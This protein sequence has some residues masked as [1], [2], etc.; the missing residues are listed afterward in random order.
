MSA[1]LQEVAEHVYKS[2]PQL[3]QVTVVF[4]NRRAALYFRKYLAEQLQRPVFTPRLL[5]I[6][7]FFQQFSDLKVPDKLELIYDLYSV[8][9]RIVNRSE[10][11]QDG[12]EGLE[13]FYFWGEMLLRDFDEADKYMVEAGHL[14]K[15]LSHQKEL[16]SSFDYLTDEQRA[17]LNDFWG[18][19]DEH[20]SHHKKKFISF[21][22]KLPEIY[23]GF[24][25]LLLETGR[26]FEGML[27]RSV[28]EQLLKG[29]LDLSTGPN[30]IFAGF[31]ALTKAE[32]HVLSTFVS[33]GAR[34]FW[35][36]DAYYV[37]NVTQE[38]GRFFREYLDHPVLRRTFP[39]NIPSHRLFRKNETG[40]ARLKVYGA[41]QPVGQAKLMSQIIEEELQK[42]MDPTETVIV[43]PDEKLLLPV[44]HG[45]AGSVEKMNVTM[46]FPLS[47]TPMFNFI[48]LLLDCQIAYKDGH[49]NHRQVLSVLG[50]PYVIGT[51]AGTANAKRKE[52]LKHN[53][54]HVPENFLASTV[55]LHRVIFRDANAA[56]HRSAAQRLVNYLADVINVLG[57]QKTLADMDKEYAFHFLKLFNRLNDILARD[58]QQGVTSPNRAE[59]KGARATEI[60]LLLRL[61]RQLVRS[62]RIP[63]VGEPLAGLQIMGV[64]ETRNLD[65]KN[66][67]VLSMNEGSFPSMA[68]TGSYIPYS[69]R[70]AYGLPTVEHQDAIYAY[71][72]YRILQ[73]AETVHLFY[74]SE[75]DVLGQGEMS[76]FLQQL[77]FESGLPF[78]KKVLHNPIV[79]RTL[80]QI[81]VGKSETVMEDL[82]KVNEGNRYFKGIS[83]SALNTYLECR[84]K[85][86][87]RHVARI[88]EADE[89]EEELDARVLGNFLHD[90]MERFYK[91]IIERKGSPQVDLDDL[92]NFE[93]VIDRLIDDV[94]IET[95]NLNPDAKVDYRG[96]R[97][98]VREI[99]S[100]FAHRI[101]EIDRQYA[102]FFIEGLEQ[103]GLTFSVPIGVK[104]FQAV[105]GG[106]IDRVDRKDNI[107]RVIDYKTG[108]DKLSFDDVPSLF[109]RD[110]K[111]NKAAFQTM[112]YALLYKQNYLKSTNGD[113]QL[114]PGLLNRMNLFDDDFSF[115]LRMGRDPVR[116]ANPLF[117]EFSLHLQQ[118]LE[119]IFDP[120]AA[121]D[122]TDD[123]EHCRNCPYTRICYR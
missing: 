67:F 92:A 7:E 47:A 17:F 80:S 16:D 2:Y 4:P 46:G 63:F 40:S 62:Q 59:V 36:L 108:K 122:Q 86:Y 20:Q 58:N 74:N 121:F 53:W 21:W 27:H 85:F 23:T 88:K 107:I 73:R 6:E 56:N 35:D 72:F 43:L 70:R 33:A 61:I 9:K 18:N 105:V 106:K 78:E 111:R 12:S 32:E 15:D 89:V 49:F 8:H 71:L 51:D 99:V 66:V 79:P 45:V 77:I 94:F 60:K 115:G 95:Y 93:P 13:H 25:A 65:F 1:F 100:R 55:D 90:V 31:N 5:T 22:R 76:R 116:D 91:G 103:S 57:V 82:L 29:E 50:H 118:V 120:K 75:T 83:P 14:F 101:I 117:E 84:L 109:T 26:A 3:E 28:A 54:V 102:P 112:L 110:S 87:F 37:N 41:A 52:I 39:D 64:L 69:I 96:Q 119:E 38:A 34:V 97:L 44:V 81:T 10:D 24:R 68:S 11:E 30:T 98:V 104:P 48:E 19:F 42:G 113:L 114:V 123:R